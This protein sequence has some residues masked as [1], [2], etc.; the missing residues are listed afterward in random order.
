[1]LIM[2]NQKYVTNKEELKEFSSVSWQVIIYVSL[3]IIVALLFD[4]FQ[5]YGL[6]PEGIVRGIAG[7]A[8]TMG[9][10]LAAIFTQIVFLVR[11]QSPYFKKILPDLGKPKAVSWVIGGFIG[12]GTAF[13]IQSLVHAYS[14]DPYGPIGV[15]YAF[16]FSNL[17]NTFA[18]LTVLIASTI[19][20]GRDGWRRYWKH[21]FYYGNAIMLILIPTVSIIVR[22]S[23]GFRPET[24]F[25]AGVESGLMDVD[26]VGA[27]II[28]LFG[29]KLLHQPVPKVNDDLSTA[30]K[31][32]KAIISFSSK[33]R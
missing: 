11:K 25:L 4:S 18:G 26:S 13:L 31:K 28:F 22:F 27:A 12:L 7:T 33:N 1:M 16:A 23:T 2:S 19:N 32:M 10:A 5:I 14:N 9:L 15:V 17:D 21:P 30:L 20:Q 3:G 8:D 29:T 24:N 6:I